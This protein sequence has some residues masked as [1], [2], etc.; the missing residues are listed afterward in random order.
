MGLFCFT[1]NK[2]LEILAYQKIRLRKRQNSSFKSP[3]PS[4]KGCKIKFCTAE[5]FFFI[6]A[7][8]TG[9][10]VERNPCLRRQPHMRTLI[11]QNAL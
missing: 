9:V 7:N 5:S 10:F 3:H 2:N 4:T 11:T 8:A 6:A 1:K